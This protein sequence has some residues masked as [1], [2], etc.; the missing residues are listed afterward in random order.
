MRGIMIRRVDTPFDL[1]PRQAWGY[2]TCMI[3]A[4]ADPTQDIYLLGCSLKG[5]FVFENLTLQLPY[6]ER[7]YC[8]EHWIFR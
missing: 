7:V 6:H 2:I 3:L 8:D 1:Q 4:P 5:V